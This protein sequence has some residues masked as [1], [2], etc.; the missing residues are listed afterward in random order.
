LDLGPDA[1]LNADKDYFFHIPHPVE[2]ETGA[3]APCCMNFA[4][5]LTWCRCLVAV[6]VSRLPIISTLEV[7]PR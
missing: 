6:Q 4:Y 1:I 7:S 3:S 2:S 5:M